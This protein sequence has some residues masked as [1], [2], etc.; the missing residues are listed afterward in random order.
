MSDYVDIKKTMKQ[1]FLLSAK[2]P[3]HFIK[4]YGCIQH[5]IRGKILFNLYPFQEKLLRLWY[6]QDYFII[7]KS[8]QIGVSTLITGYI[9]QNM[10]FQSDK[11]ML[12]IATKQDTAKNLV[13]KVR[14]MFNNLPSWMKIPVEE[15]N[16]LTLRLSNGSQVK[17]V[18]ASGDAGRSEAVSLLVIDE[19]AFIDNVDVIWASAQQTLSTGGKCI[20]ISTPNG[21][22][23][24]FHKTWVRAE[25]Q[26]NNF[27]PVRLPWWVHPERDENWRKK[28]EDILGDP[29]IAAQE[30]DCEFFSSGDTVFPSDVLKYIE[31]ATIEEPSE[32]RGVDKNLWIWEYPDY[33]R[34]YMVLADVARGDGKDYSTA[35]V[36]DIESN[37][38]VAEFK[39][40]LS[41]KD[42]G[43]FLISL[44]TEYNNALLIV[45]NSSLGWSTVETI[46][47][48][49]YRN[50]Y[51][52]SKQEQNNLTSYFKSYDDSSDLIPGFTMSQRTR[53]LCINKLREIVN[54]KSITIKSKR[55]LE[56]M[57]VFV[58]KGGRAEAQSGYN[59][60]LIMPLSIGAYLRDTSFRFKQNNLEL[61][62]CALSNIKNKK[63]EY[64]NN[65]QALYVANPY[66]MEIKG[67]K[68]DIKWLL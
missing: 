51:H 26:E 16:K 43:S 14:Y 1:E 25:S 15:D 12:C 49:G 53:P 2:D 3:I 13:T 27:V 28:Q 68:E 56:E 36:I 46:I 44:S 54:E 48:K 33:S 6:E 17:A 22:G 65:S 66:K 31:E 18:S 64:K 39:G 41:T 19:A 47:E 40:Q 20:I 50:L 55:T 34:D 59:D 63:T 5:P 62:K 45:E 23:N 29:R 60:D 61:T 67:N 52:S 10:L 37:V 58:W 7:L 11:N 38:Q 30:C 57:K 4:K 32:R 21:S 9:L 35:Q 42:F 8:R 24:F